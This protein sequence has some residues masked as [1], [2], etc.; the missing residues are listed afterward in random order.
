MIDCEDMPVT[1]VVWNGRLFL[2]WLKA[3]KQAQPA[4]AQVT[5]TSGDGTL[6]DMPVSDLASFT[7]A[8]A[9]NASQKSVTVQAVLCWT[10]FYNGK[11]QPTKTSDVNHPTTL[12]QFDPAGPGRS[13]T[14][15]P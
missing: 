1:P 7:A 11:W 8:A 9:S 2:F 10:E 6:A 5:S 4:Q 14:T 12:G 13:R 15:G 3:V